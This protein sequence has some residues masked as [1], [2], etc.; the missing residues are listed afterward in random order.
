VSRARGRELVRKPRVSRGA[1]S[2][3]VLRAHLSRE[4]GGKSGSEARI[5]A[6]SAPEVRVQAHLAGL[7]GIPPAEG[8]PGA[9][10]GVSGEPSAPGSALPGWGNRGSAPRSHPERRPR[11]PRRRHDRDRRE[12][13]PDRGERGDPGRPADREQRSPKVERHEPRRRST[14]QQRSLHG[15]LDRSARPDRGQQVRPRCHE[16]L[17]N[18]AHRERPGHERRSPG[19]L[20]ADEPR[21]VLSISA[22][23]SPA[24]MENHTTPASSPT[25]AMRCQPASVVHRPRAARTA[26]A[27]AASPTTPAIVSSAPPP[28]I[29][30]T[31]LSAPTTTTGAPSP[32]PSTARLAERRG[33]IRVPSTVGR[34][35]SSVTRITSDTKPIRFVQAC[36]VRTATSRDAAG[37]QPRST[38]VPRVAPTPTF[39]S[40]SR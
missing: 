5:P 38:R 23:A 32:T 25:L 36:A 14:T 15:V 37:S 30:P 2:P 4:L 17:R 6:D 22:D 28:A 7:R 27:S 9:H 3:D 11:K 31:P 13:C 19:A 16:H 24:P 10:L 29:T 26:R 8:A 21:G 34:K 20:V 12:P 33:T 1:G 40:A 39:A 35:W 18:P